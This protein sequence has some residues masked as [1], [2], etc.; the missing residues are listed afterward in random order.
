MHEP[1]ARQNIS[2]AEATDYKAIR[3]LL[4][5]SIDMYGKVQVHQSIT[6]SHLSM[7]LDAH[8]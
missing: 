6:L 2:C 1:N 7:L 5:A 4:R 3:V 8:G